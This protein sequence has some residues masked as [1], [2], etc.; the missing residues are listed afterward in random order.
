MCNFIAYLDSGIIILKKEG[1]EITCDVSLSNV[2][3]T[4]FKS[5][6]NSILSTYNFQALQKAELLIIDRKDVLKIYEC[7]RKFETLGRLMAEKTAL[8]ATE[9]ARTLASDKPEE[10]L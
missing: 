10:R 5:F 8:R 7:N 3:I 6:I 2:F 4:D 1:N 9:M